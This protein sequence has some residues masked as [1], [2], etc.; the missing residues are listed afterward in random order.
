MHSD[1]G[2]S[3]SLQDKNCNIRMGSLVS[4]ANEIL[5]HNYIWNNT[6]DESPIDPTGGKGDGKENDTLKT[7]DIEVRMDLTDDLLHL[8]GTFVFDDLLIMFCFWLFLVSACVLY[9]SPRFFLSWTM[10][11]FVGQL[12]FVGSGEQLALMKIFGDV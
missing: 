6:S 5:Y 12:L 11:I 7:E 1:P 2:G 8:V 4:P 9:L 10:L 3:S